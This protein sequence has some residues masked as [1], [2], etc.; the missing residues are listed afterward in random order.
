MAWTS[1]CS[2][3]FLYPKTSERILTA[4]LMKMRKKKWTAIMYIIFCV[5][6]HQILSAMQMGY[7]VSCTIPYLLFDSLV[8]YCNPIPHELSMMQAVISQE[9]LVGYLTSTGY[10][11]Q[12]RKEIDISISAR[13]H[14]W[15]LPIHLVLLLPSIP[16]FN[17][18]QTDP[19]LIWILALISLPQLS[20][21]GFYSGPT[22]CFWFWPLA[23]A[24]FHSS[25]LCVW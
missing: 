18:C 23:C 12:C 22:Q 14:L 5:K 2:V 25:E 1:S 10:W 13:Y 20:W 6:L 19:G 9:I 7:I 8:V 16:T 21:N 24:Q 17:Q 4:V 11:L 15:L 3:Q